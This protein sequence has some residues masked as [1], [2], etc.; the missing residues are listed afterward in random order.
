[1]SIHRPFTFSE[2]LS[3][4][5]AEVLKL[6]ELRQWKSSDQCW[7]PAADAECKTLAFLSNSFLASRN[8]SGFSIMK[9]CGTH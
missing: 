5:V 3:W 7:N 6:L 4:S 1:M 8:Q 9:M 2:R